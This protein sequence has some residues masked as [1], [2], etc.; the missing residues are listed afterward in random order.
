MN[1]SKTDYEFHPLPSKC[2]VHK[3]WCFCFNRL[4][5]LLEVNRITNTRIHYQC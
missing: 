3:S 2:Q 1:I 4:M 5:K